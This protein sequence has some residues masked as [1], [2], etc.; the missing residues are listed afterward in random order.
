MLPFGSKKFKLPLIMRIESNEYEV[1]STFI[2]ERQNKQRQ[3]KSKD[4]VH[5][6]CLVLEHPS[7]QSEVTTSS[8]SLV[9][10]HTYILSEKKMSHVIKRTETTF[11]CHFSCIFDIFLR[12]S[13]P[14]VRFI[15]NSALSPA[16]DPKVHFQI[17]RVRVTLPARFGLTAFSCAS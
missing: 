14:L 5:P 2:L 15:H 13:C 17:S 4:Q 9:F 7:H 6:I 11:R 1:A 3:Q 16:S 10:T 12:R 8:H